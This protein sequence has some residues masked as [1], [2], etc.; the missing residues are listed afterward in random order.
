MTTTQSDL[1]LYAATTITD[2]NRLDM[3]LSDFA[4][5]IAGPVTTSID[6]AVKNARTM[7]DMV[8]KLS[9][10]T[11]EHANRYMP[12]DKIPADQMTDTD[13]LLLVS[14]TVISKHLQAFTDRFNT[15]IAEYQTKLQES[16]ESQ[17]ESFTNDLFLHAMAPASNSVN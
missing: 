9:A 4:K 15:L 3:S 10:I 8:L 6:V 7:S 2:I 12:I 14:L 16:L 11:N 13:I 5:D 17:I 1:S